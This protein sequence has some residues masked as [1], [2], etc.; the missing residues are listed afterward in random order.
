MYISKMYD[1]NHLSYVHGGNTDYNEDTEGIVPFTV[2][3]QEKS[4]I[5]GF[6]GQRSD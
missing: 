1:G 2:A 6:S 4:A 5:K 3:S